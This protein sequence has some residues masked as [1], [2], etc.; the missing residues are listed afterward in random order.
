MA[1]LVVPL[2]E[3]TNIEVYKNIFDEKL[4]SLEKENSFDVGSVRKEKQ[5]WEY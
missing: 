3:I 2:G 5:T 4:I 1:V